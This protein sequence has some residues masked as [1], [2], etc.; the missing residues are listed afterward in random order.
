MYCCEVHYIDEWKDWFL[1]PEL[2]EVCKT[3]LAFEKEL[4]SLT[5]P[6]NQKMRLVIR[7]KQQFDNRTFV[8]HCC[9]ESI[10][11]SQTVT[12]RIEWDPENHCIDSHFFE[13]YI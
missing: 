1:D 3:Y 10:M 12:S 6:R 11:C 8:V 9:K 4:L 2:M 13:V 7:S 5:L